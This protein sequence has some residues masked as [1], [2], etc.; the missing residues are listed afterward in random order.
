[1]KKHIEECIA[2]ASLFGND[3]VIGKNRDRNYNP[4]LK[5]S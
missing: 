1:M 2:I 4:N 5:S 3:M